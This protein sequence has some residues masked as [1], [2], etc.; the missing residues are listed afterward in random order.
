MNINIILVKIKDYTFLNCILLVFV[1]FNKISHFELLKFGELYGII[2]SI[3]NQVAH[4]FLWER[5]I[6]EIIRNLLK[7]IMWVL[8]IGFFFNFVMQTV[9]YSFYKSAK[10]IT[11][12]SYE[13]CSIKFNDRLTGYGYNLDRPSDTVILFFGGSNYIAY[14]SVA[15]YS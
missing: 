15:S 13:P 9:S 2:R 5:S 8:I 4:I 7:I 3:F 1:G 14:N 10:K 6:M 12:I 11:E